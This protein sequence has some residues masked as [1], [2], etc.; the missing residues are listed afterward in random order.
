MKK[1]RK[2]ASIILTAIISISVFSQTIFAVD[3]KS[4]ISNVY[5]KM[6][7]P[8]QDE[9]NI[10]NEKLGTDYYF[11]FEYMTQQEIEE[12]CKLYSKMTVSKFS[13]YIYAAHL[14]ELDYEN[15]D[16]KTPKSMQKTDSTNSYTT[17]RYFYDGGDNHLYISADTYSSGGVMKYSTSS[18]SFGY[19][20][21]NYPGYKP[22]A[23]VTQVSNDRTKVSCTFTC[24]RMIAQGVANAY[25]TN[26]Y[27]TFT[28]GGGDIIEGISI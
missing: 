17:Q 13:E 15:D 19:Y 3:S 28:A 10:I 26:V 12:T 4:E 5:E 7:E 22:T 18:I 23:C 25:T 9:L 27:V 8:Y 16:L 11:P 2:V 1:I 20:I 14:G 6:L 24:L 21:Y